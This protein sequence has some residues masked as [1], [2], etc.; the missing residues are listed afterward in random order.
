MSLLLGTFMFIALG[1]LGAL[2]GPYFAPTQKGLMQVLAALCAFCM[3]LS[4][5]LVYISQLNPL[6]H[7]TRN[8]AGE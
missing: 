2:A 1:A 4:Y 8:I 3:W 7:P 5:A 6:I